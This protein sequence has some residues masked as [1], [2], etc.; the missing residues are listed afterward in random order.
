MAT[1]Q[2]STWLT[3]WASVGPVLTG[4]I[5]AWWSRRKQVQDREYVSSQEQRRLDT[6]RQEANEALSEQDRRKRLDWR[7]ETFIDFFGASH[8]F[9]WKGNGPQEPEVRERHR[10]RFTKCFATLMLLD[11]SSIGGEAIEL[12]DASH[13]IVPLLGGNNSQA[14][15]EAVLRLRNARH[16]FSSKGQQLLLEQMR[17]VH[18]TSDA[19]Q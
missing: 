4:A 11:Q 10:E 15:D 2:P 17:S 6:A 13:N 19:T 18:M 16:A 5:A 3:V 1:D 14:L 12:W 8:D 7:R 9:I